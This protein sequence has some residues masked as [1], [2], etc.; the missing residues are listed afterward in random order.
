MLVSVGNDMRCA[1]Y[2]A[3]DGKTSAWLTVM[4]A[5]C[6]DFDLSPVEF[7]DALSLC[8]HQYCMSSSIVISRSQ[9]A[10]EDPLQRS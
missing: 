6:H 9:G 7:R 2:Q 3:I 5:A 4:L 10:L 1:V 8:Y